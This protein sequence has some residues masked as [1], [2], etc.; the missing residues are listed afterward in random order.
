MATKLQE[1]W[2]R[3][4]QE[5]LDAV[6]PALKGADAVLVSLHGAMGADG[7]LDPEGNLLEEK[8]TERDL[9]RFAQTTSLLQP[10]EDKLQPQSGDEAGLAGEHDGEDDQCASERCA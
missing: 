6:I 3:L 5:W 7:E 2:A 10:I 1:S 9:K 8:S 4:R